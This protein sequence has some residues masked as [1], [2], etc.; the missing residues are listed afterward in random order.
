MVLLLEIWRR[1]MLLFIIIVL[2]PTMYTEKPASVSKYRSHETIHKGN[3]LAVLSSPG[4]DRYGR[5][6]L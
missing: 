3:I 4:S 5:V 2:Y 6:I 1:Q